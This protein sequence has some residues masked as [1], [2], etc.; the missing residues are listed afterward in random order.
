MNTR[1]KLSLVEPFGVAHLMLAASAIQGC[2][3]FSSIGDASIPIQAA[4]VRDASSDMSRTPVTAKL[5]I[6]TASWYGPGFNGKATASG[7]IFDDR[8]FTAAHKTLR[9]GSKA[10]VVNLSNG[11]SVEVVINDR[12]PHVEGRIIDLSEASAKALGMVERGVTQVQV[13]LIRETV[14]SDNARLSFSDNHAE[15]R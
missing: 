8:K 5:Q 4:P 15:E 10:R 14:A 9:L 6:G 11:K 13:Q 1:K 12:G 2:S 7:E 3:M